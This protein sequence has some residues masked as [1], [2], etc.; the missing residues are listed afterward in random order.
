MNEW[1]IQHFMRLLWG[2]LL[3]VSKP[4][5]VIISLFSH[6]MSSYL[7]IDSHDVQA[8]FQGVLEFHSFIRPS[9]V[10]TS[11]GTYPLTILPHGGVNWGESHGMGRLLSN[12]ELLWQKKDLL[13][14][15][16]LSSNFLRSCWKWDFGWG[17][18]LHDIA[19]LHC[20]CQIMS[21]K[22]S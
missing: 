18:R 21:G 12:R 9:R 17:K 15:L 4:H 5:F 7:L 8:A 13:S 14:P 2:M 20:T 11:V 19:C 3:C 1:T 6:S 22:L 16:P 10:S